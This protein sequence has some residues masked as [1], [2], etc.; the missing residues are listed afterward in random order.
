MRQVKLIAPNFVRNSAKQIDAF[1]NS[2][3]HLHKKQMQLLMILEF[4]VHLRK[5]YYY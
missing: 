4:I 3:H 5:K 1:D 2:I